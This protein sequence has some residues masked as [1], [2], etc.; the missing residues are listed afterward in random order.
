MKYV[1]ALLL[2]GSTAIAHAQPVYRC[3]DSRGQ[4]TLQGQPCADISVEIVTLQPD[5]GQADWDRQQKMQRSAQK[6]IAVHAESF[7]M[8]TLLQPD[9][10]KMAQSVVNLRRCHS[11]LRAAKMCGK[12]AGM[13]S[14]DENGFRREE[15]TQADGLKWSMLR[16]G[17]ASNMQQ[18][19]QQAAE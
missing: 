13:F 2:L 15:L 14:C 8:R 16:G 11:A 12:F 5:E 1:L 3:A 10:R 7:Q 19:V 6:T 17:S 4:L 18:C 9:E